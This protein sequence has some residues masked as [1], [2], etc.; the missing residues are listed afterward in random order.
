MKRAALTDGWLVFCEPNAGPIQTQIPCSRRAICINEPS[1]FNDLP[2][3]FINQFGLLIAPYRLKGFRGVWQPTHT[4]LPW[5]FGAKMDHGCLLP[6]MSL[7]QL[8]DLKLPEKSRTVSVVVSKKVFHNGHRKRLRL[9]EYLKEKLGDQLLIYGRGIREID[10]KAQA[11]LPSQLHLALEN[12]IEP[13]YWTEKLA[14][15]FLGFS[16]PVYGGCPDIHNWFSPES[17]LTVD[18]EDVSGTCEV[19][20]HALAENLYEK[21]LPQFVQP[22]PGFLHMKRRFM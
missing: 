18:P 16:L 20:R 17:M 4:G 19:I 12:T 1:P 13:S 2:A 8:Q 7:Q 11:I 6:T 14:D 15:A 22:V 21:R 9:L 5:F 10:D 3:S